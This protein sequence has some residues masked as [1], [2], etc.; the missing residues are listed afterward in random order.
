MVGFGKMSGR[1]E[2]RCIWPREGT[3]K[4]RQSAEC[5]HLRTWLPAGPPSPPFPQLSVPFPLGG[6]VVTY[7]LALQHFRF[8]DRLFDHERR[9]RVEHLTKSNQAKFYF[10]TIIELIKEF[11]TCYLD[12]NLDATPARGCVNANFGV[13]H[14]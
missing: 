2:R 6:G 9:Q 13:N 5:A 14:A 11:G 8:C 10:D 1:V 4:F 3:G 7:F 12:R